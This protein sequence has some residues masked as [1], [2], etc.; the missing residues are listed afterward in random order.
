MLHKFFNLN[1][2]PFMPDQRNIF[3]SKSLIMG[4]LKLQSILYAP[5]IAVV[6]GQVGAGKTMMVNSFVNSLDPMEFRIISTSL[7]NPSIRSLYKNIATFGGIRTAVYGDDTKLQIVSYFDEMI[8]QG[9]HTI[10][11]LDECH[12]FSYEVLDELKTFFDLKR[13]FSLILVGQSSF[14]K[15]ITHSLSLPLKQRISVFI[16]ME[17]LSLEETRAY[18]EYRLKEAGASSPIFDEKCYPTLYQLTGGIFRMIDQA[19]YQTLSTA[20]FNKQSIIT[21]QMLKDA[22]ESLNYN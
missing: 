9:K 3:E 7:T 4:K 10:V 11:I 21:E 6:T 17:D 20:Y 14:N 19:C 12:S 15:K 8:S 22:F 1:K 18:V 13:N 5:Q 2:I 16:K